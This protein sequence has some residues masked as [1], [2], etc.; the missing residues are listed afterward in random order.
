MRGRMR[1]EG[2]EGKDERGREEENEGKDERAYIYFKYL[3]FLILQ[4][5]GGVNRIWVKWSAGN[6]QWAIIHQQHGELELRHTFT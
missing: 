5:M 4:R 3:Q 2:N 1:E 6:S